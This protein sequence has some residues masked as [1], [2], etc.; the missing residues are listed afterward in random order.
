VLK[1]QPDRKASKGKRTLSPC[2]LEVI[3]EPI[4][5][6]NCAECALT[7][8]GA[9]RI[10]LGRMHDEQRGRIHARQGEGH[11]AGLGFRMTP[12]ML[13]CITYCIEPG[14]CNR[15]EDLRRVRL[16]LGVVSPL[17][18]DMWIP[19][20]E[21]ISRSEKRLRLR[22]RSDER[23]RK[24]SQMGIPGGPGSCE[25]SSALLVAYIEP[26]VLAPRALKPATIPPAHV[27]I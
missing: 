2:C 24:R 6:G 5:K 4:V 1:W 17:Y 16:R 25:P 12:N 9:K 18:R 26:L 23:R 19:G 3:R 27:T 14:F 22:R 15:R 11:T 10:R 13:H 20:C 7:T 8:R 21:M